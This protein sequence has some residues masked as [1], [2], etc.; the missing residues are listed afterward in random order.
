MITSA[1]VVGPVFGAVRTGVSH[2]TNGTFGGPG[3]TAL[4]GGG[5]GWSPKIASGLDVGMVTLLELV[6]N[7]RGMSPGW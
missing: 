1:A 3:S 4:A 6:G 2:M 5:G 7:L